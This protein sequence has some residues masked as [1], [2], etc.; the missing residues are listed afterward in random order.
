MTSG[1]QT[2]DHSRNRFPC[3][4]QAP[5]TFVR[6]LI[7]LTAAIALLVGK[8][9]A[10]PKNGDPAPSLTLPDLKGNRLALPAMA[11]GKILVIHFWSASCEYCRKEMAALEKLKAEN[12]NLFPVSISVGDSPKSIEQYLEM[13]RP[14]YPIMID[15]D[16]SI[17]TNYGVTGIPTTYVIDGKGIIRYKIFGEISAPGLRRLLK[18]LHEPAKPLPLRKKMP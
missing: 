4:D 18:T 12:K 17:A 9:E 10:F 2:N 8:A 14:S 11:K 3:F 6:V 5:L 7:I 13:S 16:R 1:Q 15:N